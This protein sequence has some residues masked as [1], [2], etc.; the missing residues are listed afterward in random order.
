M[1]LIA[2]HDMKADKTN[3]DASPAQQ[4]QPS[5]DYAEQ[6]LLNSSART[7]GKY[8]VREREKA[9]AAAAYMRQRRSRL[10]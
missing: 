8:Q 1:K 7:T 9:S 3:P 5:L 2:E 4:P 6:I 10:R